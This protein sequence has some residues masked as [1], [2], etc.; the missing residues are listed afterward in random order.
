MQIEDLQR[1]PTLFEV[2][3]QGIDFIAIEQLDELT[4]QATIAMLTAERTFVFL[5]QQGGLISYFT[6]LTFAFRFL[7]VDDGAQMQFTSADMSVI[8]AA[9]AKIIQHFSEIIHVSG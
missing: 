9:Q 8:D 4:T 3:H 5:D 1:V 7:D 2:L 6:E